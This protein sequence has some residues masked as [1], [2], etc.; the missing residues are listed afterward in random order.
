MIT[1]CDRNFWRKLV[2]DENGANI[3]VSFYGGAKIIAIVDADWGVAKDGGI[4]WSF[5]EDRKLFY[6]LTK[7]SAVIMGR[8]TFESL[9]YRPLKERVNC[10][11]SR[12]QEFPEGVA[13]N[14]EERLIFFKSLED[15]LSVF[16]DS[17]IIGG[18]EIYNYALKK[19]LVNHAIITKMHQKFG[20][21]KFIEG[22]IL[23]SLEVFEKTGLGEGPDY[24]LLYYQKV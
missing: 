8:K 6:E 22:A 4:P 10:V 7:N 23:E 21:D 2:G 14:F 19:S 18:A 9:S 3:R 11:V 1:T 17:W 12:T 20:A 13:P 24:E 15:A 16:E 5:E